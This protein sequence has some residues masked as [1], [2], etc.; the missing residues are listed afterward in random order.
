MSRLADI[1]LRALV[2][3]V[4]VRGLFEARDARKMRRSGLPLR[5]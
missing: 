4:I 3:V 1:A 2:V 5:A